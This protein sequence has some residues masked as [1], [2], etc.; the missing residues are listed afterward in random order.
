MRKTLD[1]AWETLSVSQQTQTTK[2]EMAQGIIL[3]IADKGE[4]DPLRLRTLAVTAAIMRA[5]RRESLIH[6]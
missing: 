5:H 4:R 2:S 3:H 6:G 1:E